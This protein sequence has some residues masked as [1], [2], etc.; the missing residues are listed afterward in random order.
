MN[1]Q[2]NILLI[3]TDQQRFDTISALGNREI[4]TPHLNWL[5]DE[6]LSFTSCYSACPLCMPARA[7][8]MTGLEAHHHGLTGNDAGVFPLQGRDTLPSVLTA[9]GYQ[10]CAEGKMHFSPMRACY[11]FERVD[12]PLDY[13]NEMRR[14]GKQTT[15][16]HGI[17]E[18]ELE[19]VINCMEERDTLTH[20]I[21]E[22]SVSFIENHDPTRPFFLWTSFSKPHP[23]L[24]PLLPYWKLYENMTLSPP[25][26]GDW[27][28]CGA[29]KKPQ[30]FYGPT[31]RLNNAWRM[32]LEQLIQVKKAYYACITQIDYNLG[33]LFARMRELS[34]LENTWIIFTADHG[35]MLGDHGMGA[36]YHHLEGS[37]HVP[38][39]I[40]PPAVFG[41]SVRELAGKRCEKLATLADVMPTILS[42]CG[43]SWEGPADGVDLLRYWKQ[44]EERAFFGVCENRY[45]AAMNHGIKYL[46]SNCNDD[47]LLFDLNHDP[48]ELYDL[49]KDSQY[50]QEKERLNE[51]LLARIAEVDGS[52]VENGRLRI[53]ECLNDPREVSRFPGLNTTVFPRDS[54][55]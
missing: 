1:R 28:Q 10:T 35:D 16:L 29:E 3:T 17:G 24:D 36:K 50:A 9:A 55:H 51:F 21:V 2:P 6:G 18:N 43:V 40:K 42:L 4:F 5:V 15:R 33:L 54:I 14:Y 30:A 25:V 7:T 37:C 13:F 32:T 27:A 48:Q 45:F 41:E 11:G 38:L 34:L 26:M 31:Y 12:L 44:G 53:K 20:W 49:S 23:P 22:K 39:I 19:P 47:E 52:L 46:R 8:L